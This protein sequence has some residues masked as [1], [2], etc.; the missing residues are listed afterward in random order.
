M[1]LVNENSISA[2]NGGSFTDFMPHS[3][4]QWLQVLEQHLLCPL[5]QPV[6]NA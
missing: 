3:L 6:G 1:E 4:Q 5:A 2:E